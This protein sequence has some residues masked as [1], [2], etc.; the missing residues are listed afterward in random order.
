MKNSVKLWLRALRSG[1]YKQTEGH[2][3]NDS[4]YCCLGVA[5]EL[6]NKT[7]KNKLSTFR[8]VNGYFIFNEMAYELPD[9]VC[10]WLGLTSSA[11]F[12][13]QASKTV[14]LSH[15]N[16]MGEPFSEIADIIESNP[17]RLF[18]EETK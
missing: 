13:R 1:E 8:H 2:L 3:K 5:C 18:I 12:Y 17:S 7:H 14:G 16:D 10:K 6:Y 11:G 4:G 15:L 9:K